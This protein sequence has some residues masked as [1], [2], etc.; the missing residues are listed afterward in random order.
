MTKPANKHIE[1]DFFNLS[2][3]DAGIK[4]AKRL[5]A[6]VGAPVV[7]VEIEEK[8]RRSAGI[9]YRN[10]SFAFG[11]SQV[12]MMSVKSTGD[13]FQV[14][15]NGK[16][17][18]LAKPDE[19]KAAIAEIVAAMASGRTK[20][21]AAL[22][23]AKVSLPATIKTAAPKMQEQLK[24]I[25]GDKVNA[26]EQAKARLSDLQ[27]LS[28]KRS[29]VLGEESGNLLDSLNDFLVGK[30]PMLCGQIR[31]ALGRTM[32][33]SSGGIMSVQQ[34]IWELATS[35]RLVLDTFEEDKIKP[36]TR[37]QFNRA[38]GREQDLHEARIKAGGKKTV[39][40]VSNIDLGKLAY[41]YAQ[42]LL[43]QRADGK[44]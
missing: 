40:L 29:P 28:T 39:Y 2:N 1:F 34:K 44:K 30:S 42:H 43:G 41:D 9:S 13:I 24:T 19:Q 31:K 11:D 6:Q 10:V 38:T 25:L 12:V 37:S 22:A 26:L 7:S 35:G 14:K 33:F 21:Q 15:L 5:F 32:N 27:S 20:F 36:L 17:L 16:V 23:K 18:A 8:L 4:A 3:K